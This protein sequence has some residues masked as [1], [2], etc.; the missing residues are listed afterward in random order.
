MRFRFDNVDGDDME[1]TPPQTEDSQERGF[2]RDLDIADLGQSQ[3]LDNEDAGDIA[4]EGTG[5]RG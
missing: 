5:R 3:E 2:V 1:R 4:D